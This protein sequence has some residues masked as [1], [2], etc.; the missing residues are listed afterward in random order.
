MMSML[1]ALALFTVIV[2][3]M[4]LVMLV[5]VALLTVLVVMMLVMLVAM[6]LFTVI[7]VMMLVMLV[8]VAFLTVIVVMMM[9]VMLVAVALFTVLVVMML[10]MLV[11]M[12][13]HFV[14]VFLNRICALHCIEHL[15]CRK[16]CPIGAYNSCRLVML[17]NKLY[18]LAKLLLARLLCVTEDNTARVLYLIVKELTEVLHIHL[19]LSGI[20]DD[21]AAI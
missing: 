19:A 6:A 20:N 17:T 16:L 8:A 21:R 1:V 13:K 4:M 7:V 2:V 12:L 15:L 5:A 9:L 18:R 3:M 14:K 11:M 10:V